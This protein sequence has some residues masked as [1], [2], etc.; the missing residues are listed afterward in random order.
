MDKKSPEN[1]VALH[2]ALNTGCSRW[3]SMFSTCEA[4]TTGIH[5]ECSLA[6]DVFSV[7]Q[8]RATEPQTNEK[9]AIQ[10]KRGQR[11]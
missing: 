9:F 11:S 8:R 4:K 5:E 7:D 2:G 10:L 6:V 3:V 1:I